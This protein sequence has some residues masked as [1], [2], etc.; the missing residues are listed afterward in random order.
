MTASEIHEGRSV[1]SGSFSGAN[2]G[3]LLLAL[4]AERPTKAI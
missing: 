4:N 2:T 3:A 1:E